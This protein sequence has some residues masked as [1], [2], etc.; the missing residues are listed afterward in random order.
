MF[1][2][3][4]VYRRGNMFAIVYHGEVYMKVSDK[5]ARSSNRDPFRPNARQTLRSYRLVSPDELEDR[6]ELA[7][8]ARRAQNAAETG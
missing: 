2:G 5:E 8:M 4:G 3:H 1:G 7:A 6:D